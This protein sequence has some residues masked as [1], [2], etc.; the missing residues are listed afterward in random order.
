MVDAGIPQQIIKE[1]AP[2][3]EKKEAAPGAKK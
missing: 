3:E 1:I 2:V